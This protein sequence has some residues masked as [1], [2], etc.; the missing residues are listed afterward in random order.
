[1]LL[2]NV[3]N[4]FQENTAITFKTSKVGMVDLNIINLLGEIVHVEEF[5]A[6][7]GVN[8][9]LFHN[10]SLPSGIYTYSLRMGDTTVSKRM[11]IAE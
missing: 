3:P 8:E 2:Q 9:I 4:P 1:M 11:V 7:T 5:A 10:K 6:E